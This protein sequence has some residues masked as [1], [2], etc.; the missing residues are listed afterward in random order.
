VLVV[1]A[2]PPGTGKTTLSRRLAMDLRAALLRVDV[3]EAALLRSGELSPPLG[4]VGYV[5]AQEVAACCLAVGTR[6]V[7]D[8][9]NPTAEARAGWRGIAAAA[10]TALFVFEVVLGDAVEHRRRVEQRQS[11]LPGLVVPTWQQVVERDYQ[12]WDV[13]RDG[14]RVVVDGQDT[15]AALAVIYAGLAS[16]VHRPRPMNDR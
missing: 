11:D 6:T 3:I 2:G 16:S 8:A 15:R 13:E 4:P 12:P 7:V 1:F 10:G 14:G 5:M 9:V